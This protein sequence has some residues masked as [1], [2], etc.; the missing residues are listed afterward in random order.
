MDLITEAANWIWLEQ[1]ATPADLQSHLAIRAGDT[2]RILQR[3]LDYSVVTQSDDGVWLPTPLPQHFFQKK[4]RSLY[5]T[6]TIYRRPKRDSTVVGVV[7]PQQLFLTH[8]QRGDWWLVC[9][10]QGRIGYINVDSLNL[11]NIE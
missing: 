3:L 9:N 6:L 5:K 7:E 1:R 11:V 2:L 10:H 8:A 4:G